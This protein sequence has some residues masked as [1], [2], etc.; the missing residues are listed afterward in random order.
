MQKKSYLE[1]NKIIEAPHYSVT[2]CR[3]CLLLRKP[4]WT[5]STNGRSQKRFVCFSFGGVFIEVGRFLLH[6]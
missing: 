6:V 1:Y 5:A 4:Y 2:D 3:V